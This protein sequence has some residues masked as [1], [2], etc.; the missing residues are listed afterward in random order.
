M[1]GVSQKM[2]AC[3]CCDCIGPSLLKP[4]N[5]VGRLESGR[6]ATLV[7]AIEPQTATALPEAEAQRL[8]AAPLASR[9]RTLSRSVRCRGN[10]IPGL[11]RPADRHRTLLMP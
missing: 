5:E 11:P 2:P 6:R 9:A 4:R 10:G 7:R 1:S 8:T 3:S